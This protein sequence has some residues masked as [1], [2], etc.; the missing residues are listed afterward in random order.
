MKSIA[1]AHMWWP[2]MD[3]DI[4]DFTH[5]CI[6][7]QQQRPMPATAQLHPWEFP[8]KA[9][10]RI[11]VD[12][13]GPFLGHMF[14]VIVDAYSKWVDIHMMK[15]STS[16]AT[17]NKLRETFAIHGLPDILVSDNGTCF[18][19]DEFKSYMK[20]NG[21]K[22]LQSAPYHPSSNGLAENAVKSFKRAL[23]K[24]PCG[25]VEERLQTYLFHQHHTSLYDWGATCRTIDE[26]KTEI[27]A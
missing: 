20:R 16:T 11:H 5:S 9:W 8:G 25:T 23:K 14:L 10:S 15:T 21:I 3:N 27:K 19:S 13:A 24:A 7:C 1:R 2:K 4:E 18:T 26:S 17:I 22:M 12:Y 6:N